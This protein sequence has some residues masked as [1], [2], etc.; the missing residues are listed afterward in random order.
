MKKVV[1]T[2]ASRRF[3]VDLDN[4][5]ADFLSKNLQENQVS[6]DEDNEI[7]QLLQLYLKAVHKEYRAEE[8]IRTIIN[9]IEESN[10]QKT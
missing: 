8:Q 2:I 4:D 6:L 7:S 5:F 9:K 1:F 3:E 10:W